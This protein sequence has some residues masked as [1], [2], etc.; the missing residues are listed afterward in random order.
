MAQTNTPLYG[1]AYYAAKLTEFARERELLVEGAYFGTTRK[2]TRGKC[3]QTIMYFL[4]LKHYENDDQ[5]KL[6]YE[7]FKE[8][9]NEM[10][11]P[12]YDCLFKPE[13]KNENRRF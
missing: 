5:K 10:A 13:V 3:C 6:V 8:L 11:K 1:R 4:S 7:H 12:E 2:N 9:R